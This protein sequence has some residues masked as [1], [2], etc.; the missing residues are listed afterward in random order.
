MKGKREGSVLWGFWMEVVLVGGGRALG[1]ALRVG[2]FS[3][4]IAYVIF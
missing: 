3:L 4:E 1:N 2:L